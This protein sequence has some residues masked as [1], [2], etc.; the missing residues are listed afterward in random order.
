MFINLHIIIKTLPII[1]QEKFEEFYSMFSYFDSVRETLSFVT[2]SCIRGR[3]TFL[4]LEANYKSICQQELA[5][6]R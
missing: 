1:L 2:V 3:T 6:H 4:P 5:R